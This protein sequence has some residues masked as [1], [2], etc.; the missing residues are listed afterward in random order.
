MFHVECTESVNQGR[1][2]NLSREK[3]DAEFLRP[4]AA[5]RTV[6]IDET[7]YRPEKGRLR[8]IEAPELTIAELGLGRGW[9]T[10]EKNGQ[11]VTAQV[12][13][14]ARAGTPPAPQSSDAVKEFKAAVLGACSLEPRPLG[15]IVRLAAV[16]YPTGRASECLAL[17]EQ[18]VWE[19]LHRQKLALH[20]DAD[21]EPVPTERWQ[22]LLLAW[23]SWTKDPAPTVQAL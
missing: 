13:G 17:A 11:D 20:I 23:D 15:D 10:V 8:V 6:E 7:E 1:R 21:S 9:Q 14:E 16:R 5:G 12:M 22:E 3:L 2:F 19:L 18:S 4:W